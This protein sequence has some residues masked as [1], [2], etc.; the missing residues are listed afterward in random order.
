MFNSIFEPLLIFILWG[1]YHKRIKTLT[2]QVDICVCAYLHIFIFKMYAF[3]YVYIS[4]A[5]NV[6][7]FFVLP[8]RYRTNLTAAK[9][10]EL[11]QKVWMINLC[12]KAPLLKNWVQIYIYDLLGIRRK[13]RTD[14]NDNSFFFPN[15]QSQS[16]ISATRP[17]KNLITIW[18]PWLVVCGHPSPSRKDYILTPKS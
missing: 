12:V 10:N 3:V 9:K 1:E 16:S 6:K 14:N 18:Q 11:V 8:F 17:I 15:R 13:G 7:S 4:K 5:F 2:R